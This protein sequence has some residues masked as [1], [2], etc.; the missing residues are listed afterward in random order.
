MRRLHA[1]PQLP[2]ILFSISLCLG[3]PALAAADESP[4]FLAN[5]LQG[6]D[7][8][9]DFSHGNTYPAI[10]LP[11]PMNTWAP[12]T[13]P[14]KDSFYYQYHSTEIRGIRETHQ[15]SAWIP[16]YGAF[17]FMPSFGEL[18]L[19]EDHRASPFSHAREEARPSYYKTYLDKWGVTVEVT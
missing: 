17:A 12:Y 8:S 1:I 3:H 9:W 16:E 11:F 2:L 4:V 5:P 18:A 19:D 13:Q 10:A 15:P 6:T 7:P 14:Q